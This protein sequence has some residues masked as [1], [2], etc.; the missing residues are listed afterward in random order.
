MVILMNKEIYE[1]IISI[2]VYSYFNITQD[3]VFMRDSLSKIDEKTM[4]FFDASSFF[5]FHEKYMHG[6]IR[7]AFEEDHGFSPTGIALGEDGIYIKK[8]DGNPIRA[9]FK[10]IDSKDKRIALDDIIMNRMLQGNLG[11]LYQC[12][13]LRNTN[14]NYNSFFYGLDDSLLER[15]EIGAYNAEDVKFIWEWIK[16]S[17]RK[18]PL[19]RF[20]LN[21]PDNYSFS[22][23]NDI[24][25][26]TIPSKE[27][28]REERTFSS[29]PIEYTYRPP[30]NDD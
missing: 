12:D 19:I 27:R 29:K 25:N 4:S 7:G 15:I 30:Y 2:E 26:E 10:N 6:R 8:P 9:L 1:L 22:E 20:L 17:N 28:T 13:K 5:R 3:Y 24:F 14:G 21:N 11:T 16:S 18:Y 23:M